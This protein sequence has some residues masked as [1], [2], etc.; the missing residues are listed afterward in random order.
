MEGPLGSARAGL[1]GRDGGGFVPAFSGLLVALRLLVS[2]HQPHDH[3]D[4]GEVGED[5]DEQEPNAGEVE[6]R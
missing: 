3:G 5:A 1:S 6:L 2:L 4:E